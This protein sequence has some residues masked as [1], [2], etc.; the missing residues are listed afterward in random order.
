MQQ[1]FTGVCVDLQSCRLHEITRRRIGLGAPDAVDR[2]VIVA[3]AIKLA[4]DVTDNLH[5]VTRNSDRCGRGLRYSGA[6][7]RGWRVMDQGWP[8]RENRRWMR[9]VLQEQCV[10]KNCEGG[11]RRHQN[12]DEFTRMPA[13]CGGQQAHAAVKI[14]LSAASTHFSSPI[15]CP[16]RRIHGPVL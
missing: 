2:A 15:Y 6:W 14:A 8:G 12:T 9:S 7:Q 5:R 11:H 16:P 4:L 13:D 3:F 1:R 10:D